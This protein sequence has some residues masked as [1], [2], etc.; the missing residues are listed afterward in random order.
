MGADDRAR[1][2]ARYASAREAPGPA[3]RWLDAFDDALPRTGRALDVASGTGRMAR[4][5][6]ARGLE[7]T[8]IDVSPVALAHLRAGAPGVET[9]ERDLERD[10][11]LPEGGFALVTVMHYRQPSLWPAIAGALAP[12]GVLV[13]ELALVANL[14]RHAHPSRRWLAEPGE[15]AGAARGLTIVHLE[16]GWL[17]DRCTARLI[18]RRD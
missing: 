1:W 17:D 9:I 4:W 16:E 10:P 2:D 14:E 3:P 11:R 6:L 13:A 5:A 15:L 8:A 12:G 7:V 18:A